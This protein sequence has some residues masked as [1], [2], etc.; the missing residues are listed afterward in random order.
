MQGPNPAVAQLSESI[1]PRLPIARPVEPKNEV[2]TTFVNK[3]LCENFYTSLKKLP[4][5]G[6]ELPTLGS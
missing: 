1:N 4:E 3:S 2:I 6:F 5:G